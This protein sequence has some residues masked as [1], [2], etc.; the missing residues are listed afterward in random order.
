VRVGS[1]VKVPTT[2]NR[3]NNRYNI[4]RIL[5]Q[6]PTLSCIA[7]DRLIA[8]LIAIERILMKYSTIFTVPS[9]PQPLKKKALPASGRAFFFVRNEKGGTLLP[10]LIR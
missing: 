10:M 4:C 7:L 1:A 5:M 2:L 6:K 8:L 3:Y 9:R